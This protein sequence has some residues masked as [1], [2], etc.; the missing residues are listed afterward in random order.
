MGI[1]FYV[2]LA[3]IGAQII[4]LGVVVYRGRKLMAEIEGLAEK[5]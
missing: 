5:F 1:L 2:Q 4:A 3:A